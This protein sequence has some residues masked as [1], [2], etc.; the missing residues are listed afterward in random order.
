MRPSVYYYKPEMAGIPPSGWG[1]VFA[2]GGGHHVSV[3]LDHKWW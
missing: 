3:R 2:S 1:G